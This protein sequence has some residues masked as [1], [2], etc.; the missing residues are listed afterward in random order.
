[1]APAPEKE[2]FVVPNFVGLLV[3]YFSDGNGEELEMLRSRLAGALCA[4]HKLLES[5]VIL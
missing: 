1:M 3:E 5:W 4:R 2:V